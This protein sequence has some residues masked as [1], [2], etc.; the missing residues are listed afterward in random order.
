MEFRSQ[1][2]LEA[3]IEEFRALGYPIAGT[4]KVIS[5]D[6]E[7]GANT[8]LV[9]A[10]LNNAPTVVYIQPSSPDAVEWA[11]TLE[12]RDAPATLNAPGVLNL[13]A[14][15]AMLSALCAFLQAKS[16]SF[17]HRDSA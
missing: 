8:G 6:G 16:Q 2:T 10:R 5:Q 4:I 13:A 17:L 15:L 11:V 9:S 7:G 12:S 3:W 14:E 1:E